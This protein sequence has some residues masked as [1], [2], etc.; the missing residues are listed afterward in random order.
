M[1]SVPRHRFVPFDVARFA[2]DDRPL[3]I[4]DGQTISQPLVVALMTRALEVE[5][6]D[7]ILDIGTGSGYQAAVLADMGAEVF[8]IEIVPALAEEAT[9]T[10]ADLG[11]RTVTVRCADGYAGWV[12]E[13]PFDGVLVAAALDHVPPQLISQLRPGGRLVMPVG[14]TGGE[15][16][17]SIITKD[18]AGA[19]SEVDLGTVRFVP[20]TRSD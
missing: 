15:Q 11:Y 17:L 12:E 1:R 13:A 18:E 20:F 6:G 8:T 14:A 4:G 10:L 7:R 2:Y 16:V 9:H 5:P 19:V 3:P